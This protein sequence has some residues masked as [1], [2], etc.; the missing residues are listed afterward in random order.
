[1]FLELRFLEESSWS[2]GGCMCPTM[3][4]GCVPGG[5]ATGARIPGGCAPGARV[6]GHCATGARIPGRCAPGVRVPG[7]RATGA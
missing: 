4:L 2:L 3:F 6:P 7:R 5:C 1:V